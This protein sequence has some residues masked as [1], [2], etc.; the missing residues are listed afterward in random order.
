MGILQ[1][2]THSLAAE[3]TGSH[4]PLSQSDH[5]LFV[6]LFTSWTRHVQE[7]DQGTE[8]LSAAGMAGPVQV[9]DEDPQEAS[10]VK[11]IAKELFPAGD[12]LSRSDIRSWL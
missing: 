12:P 6:V 1:C 4:T 2:A 7:A 5:S 10:P 8:G 9:V 3:V 11:H